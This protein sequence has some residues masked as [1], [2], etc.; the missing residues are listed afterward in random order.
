MPALRAS[1]L[2]PVGT[3]IRNVTAALIA[4]LWR[5]RSQDEIE[6][7]LK[8]LPVREQAVISGS[9]LSALFLTSLLFAQLGLVGLAAFLLVVILIVR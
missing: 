3:M 5:S 8:A 1:I 6:A 4:G 9:V 2:S 7:R